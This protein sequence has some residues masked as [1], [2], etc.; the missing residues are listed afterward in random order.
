VVFRVKS[1]IFPMAGGELAAPEWT[2]ACPVS[3]APD[4]E[5]AGPVM[6]ETDP[7][8]RFEAALRLSEDD[9]IRGAE[10]LEYTENDPDERFEAALRLS[11][12][13]PGRAA[14]KLR[15]IAASDEFDR[16]TRDEAAHRLSELH[17]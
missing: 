1:G 2:C 6:Y 8:D 10:A 12:I 11:E 16:D 13:D 3:T 7:S 17:D 5:K 15:G 4:A 14:A 9:P